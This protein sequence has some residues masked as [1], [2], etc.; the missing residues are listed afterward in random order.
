M[1]FIFILIYFVIIFLV[2]EIAV[3]LFRSTGLKRDISR[4][5]VV[6]MM[7]GTGFTTKESE[8]ILRHPVRRNIGMFLILFG[9]FSLAV[10]ISSISTIMT[11][12][13]HI[14]QLIWT[15]A[16][17]GLILL[18]LRFPPVHSFITQWFHAELQQNFDLKELPV[19]ESFEMNENDLFIDISIHEDSR[20]IG[21]SVKDLLKDDYDIN[22]LFIKRGEETIRKDR[23]STELCSGDLIFVYG[24]K[25]DLSRLF[26]EELKLREQQ[27]HDEKRAARLNE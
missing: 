21:K 20:H 25:A 12:S 6:S 17:L 23:M 26:E 9:A 4:F 10:I 16:V 7:T 15:A 19:S 2:L 24:S 13:F 8:L 5:Q 1:G 18:V 14:P 22:L 11:K 3:I 27:E